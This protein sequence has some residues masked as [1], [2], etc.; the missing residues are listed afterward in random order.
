MPPTPA[1]HVPPQNIE[2]E[3]RVLGAML[4]TGALTGAVIDEVK[5]TAA[6]FYL[7]RHRAIFDAIH[8]LY[9]ASKPVDEL[10]VAEALVDR[11]AGRGSS[12]TQALKYIGG[13]ATLEEL[14]AKVPAAGNAKHYAEI[15]Q[16]NSLLRRLLEAGQEIQGWVNERDGESPEELIDRAQNLLGQVRGIRGGG[17]SLAPKDALASTEV[18][19]LEVIREGIPPRQFVPGGEPWLLLGKRYLA[20]APAGTGKSLVGLIAAIGVVEAGG[21]VAILDVENGADEYARRLADVL[22]GRGG[23]S[24][25]TAAACAD[26]LHY[27]EY[28]ALR[29]TWGPEDWAAALR[30]VDLAIFDSSRLMLS[31]AGL[32]EDS[33]DDYATFVDSLIVPLARSGTATLILDN[34]GHEERERARGASAKADLNEVVYMV[35]VGEEF[36]RDQT[37]HLRLVRT[38]TRFSELPGE[39]HVPIGGGAYGPITEA[40]PGEDSDAFRPTTLM[41]RIAE[42]LEM[43][44]GLSK[45]DIR[46]AV[47]G[48]SDAID[49][50]LR[51]LVAEKWVDVRP[52]GQARRHFNK[53]LYRASEDSEAVADAA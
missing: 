22:D 41:E 3:E 18:D 40:E 13:N 14:A 4:I 9:A 47:R 32:A 23:L 31:G 39:L 35:K 27:F 28:P 50:A 45:S 38:R 6:D 8:D 12:R 44:P 19:L 5:L 34:T 21:T 10:S 53:R 20:P 37:G 48:K 52:D 29:V 33:N 25:E 36:D 24:G 1:T 30:G 16:R 51:T 26:R 15:V 43:E 17:D 49:L 42:A 11:K 7:D 2:A 46:R